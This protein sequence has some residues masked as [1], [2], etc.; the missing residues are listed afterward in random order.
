MQNRPKQIFKLFGVLLCGLFINHNC[1]PTNQQSRESTHYLGFGRV[2][3]AGRLRAHGRGG[4][5][6]RPVP[7]AEVGTPT[8]KTRV[9]PRTGVFIQGVI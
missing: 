5:A 6:P 9:T 8:K 7:K 1:G 3:E 2:Q 4:R